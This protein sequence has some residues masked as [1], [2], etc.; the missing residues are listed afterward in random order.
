[1]TGC[2]AARPE[3]RDD[4]YPGSQMHYYYLKFNFYYPDASDGRRREQRKLWNDFE[5]FVTD[6]EPMQNRMG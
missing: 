5:G 2:F 3:A 6:Q 4:P 1:M